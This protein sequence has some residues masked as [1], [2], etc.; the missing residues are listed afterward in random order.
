MSSFAKAFLIGLVIVVVAVGAILVMQRG[1][2]MDLPGQM[3]VRTVATDENTALALVDLHLTNPSDY[4][5]MVKTVTVIL[6][7]KT[8]EFPTET[9]SRID[10]QRLFDA[11]PEAGPYHPTLYYKAIIPAHSTSDYTVAAQFSAPESILKDRKRFVVR[12]EEFNGKIV[13]YSE[14]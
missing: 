3:K 14:K 12:I 13:E 5:F 8:G 6:E 1:A 11:K 7:T 10:A 2:R 9:I 4:S